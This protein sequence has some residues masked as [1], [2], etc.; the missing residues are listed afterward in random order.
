M[1]SSRTYRFVVGV[2]LL[3]L[4]AAWAP[5]INHAEAAG[6]AMAYGDVVSGQITNKSYYEMWQFNGLKGDRVQ[7]L[8]QGDGQ[9][10][11]YLGLLDGQSQE[12]L[13]ED[14]DS[15]G[16]SDAYIEFT[17]P[18]PGTYFIV[19]TRY[20]LDTGTTQ[21]QYQLGL[22]GGS[23][24]QNVSTTTTTTASGPQEVS[25]GVFFMGEMAL[26]D[27]MQGQITSTAYAQIYSIQ[28]QKGTDLMIGQ[29]AD[30]SA[31]DAYLIFAT[32]NGDV[33]AEDNDSGA[34]VGGAASDAFI[35]LTVPADGT[36]LIGATRAGLDTG[37]SSGAYVLVAGVPDT[38][39]TTNNDQTNTSQS[40]PVG[41]E[42]I[43][44]IVVGSTSNGTITADSFLHLYYFEGNAGDQVT[45][46]MTGSGGLDSYLGLIDPSDNVIA[47]DDDSAGGTN[48]Q[49]SARLPESG[50]YVIIATRAGLEQGS[51]LG[52]YTLTLIAGTPPAPAGGPSIGGFGG[53]PGRALQTDAGTLYL[54]GMGKS[55]NP[56]KGTPLQQFIDSSSN[57]PGRTGYSPLRQ[58]ISLNFEEIKFK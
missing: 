27:Q 13:A 29:F 51:S 55:D 7:I 19:A 31:L 44:D 5:V 12:V 42:R 40:L 53:L 1:S 22:A 28:L 58:G 32:E 41:W 30:N 17:L 3:A 24:P 39:T 16:N 48:A 23:G 6:G 57:L 56:A 38:S 18:A 34:Q 11:P 46:T 52:A 4:V 2:M 10:D 15:G 8:M 54:R 26:G 20:G 25:P 45:I 36:Y 21:G 35:H 37:T 9:L 47:E 14:D 49:I 50:W 43:G 33:L